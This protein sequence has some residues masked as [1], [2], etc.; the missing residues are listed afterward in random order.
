MKN[1]SESSKDPIHEDAEVEGGQNT[2]DQCFKKLTHF[3]DLK[4]YYPSQHGE[5]FPG[6]QKK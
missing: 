3:Y 2:H 1:I 4:Q 6:F 5:R